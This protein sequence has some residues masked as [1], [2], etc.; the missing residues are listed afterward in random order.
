MKPLRNLALA[1]L[2]FSTSALAADKASGTPKVKHLIDTHIHLYDTEREGGVPWPYPDDKVLYKPHHPEEYTR[3]AKAAGVTGVVI[4]EASHLL[5]DNQ[6]MLDWVKDEPFYL[7]LVGNIDPYRKDYAEQIDKLR[8]DKRFV[9]IR[10]RNKGRPIDFAD[11]QVIK[12]FRILADR[13]LSADI[14]GNGKGI[15]MVEQI[16]KLAR[17]IPT[18]RIVF[19]H[20]LGFKVDGSEPPAEWVAAVKKLGENKNVYCKVSGLYQRCIA[21]PASKDIATYRPAL[22]VVWEAFG[23]KRLIYGSNWPCTKRSGDYQSFVDLVST[24]FTEK[25]QEA[26]ER[27]FWQNASEAYGL[28][29]K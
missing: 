20:I 6:G 19:D 18:L 15:T 22:D 2:A 26:C 24:Y 12:N 29:L 7:G 21:Q 5:P 16:D 14:L 25:G 3:V 4:V 23:P 9:G 1:A 10:A 13:S 27:Y 28:G 11:E 8:S 17:E